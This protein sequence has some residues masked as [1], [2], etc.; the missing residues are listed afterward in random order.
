MEFIRT[1]AVGPASVEIYDEMA[2][3]F[4]MLTLH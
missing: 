2:R 4:E 3:E 1:L